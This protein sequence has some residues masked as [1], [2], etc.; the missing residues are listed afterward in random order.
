MRVRTLVFSSQFLHFKCV[1]AFESMWSCIGNCKLGVKDRDTR[2][3]R[4]AH[5]DFI[6]QSISSCGW[7]LL[8]FHIFRE[9]IRIHQELGSQIGVIG[10]NH[11]RRTYSLKHALF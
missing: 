3:A 5:A 9:A 8:L 1:F 7:P 11:P 2:T 10:F 4:V 6:Q